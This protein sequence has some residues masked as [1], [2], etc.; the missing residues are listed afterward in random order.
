MPQRSTES[1]RSQQQQRY[2]SAQGYG[3]QGYYS[4]GSSRRGSETER[5]RRG[6][7]YNERQDLDWES[8]R[9]AS[10]SGRRNANYDTDERRGG[11]RNYGA[12]RDYGTRDDYRSSESEYGR[13]GSR[14]GQGRG[15]QGQ[16]RGYDEDY[17]QTNQSRGQGRGYEGS[18][19]RDYNEDEYG[20][21][22]RG[23]SEDYLTRGGRSSG[24]SGSRNDRYDDQERYGRNRS[25]ENFLGEEDYYSEQDQ[26]FYDDTI[27][28]RGSSWSDED[29]D[30]YQDDLS[31]RRSSY[32]NR[33]GMY[34]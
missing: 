17:F 16:G 6:S 30:S 1:R 24:R 5:G 31:D 26:D 14:Y 33:P 2:G 19:R 7:S 10:S 32:R 25:N 13:E 18:S 20:Y 3:T 12:S 28:A 34:Y 9:N 22:G 23:S 11:V 8:G 21:R 15:R 4:Q 27:R 29:E